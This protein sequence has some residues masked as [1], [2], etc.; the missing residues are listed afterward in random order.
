MNE[1]S[2]EKRFVIEEGMFNTKF[3]VVSHYNIFD[4]MKMVERREVSRFD[5]YNE[6]ETCILK[7]LDVM[8]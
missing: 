6:A 7:K 5:T 8:K 1:Y 2:I 4:D 3:V